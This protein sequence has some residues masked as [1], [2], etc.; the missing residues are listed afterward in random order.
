MKRPLLKPPAGDGEIIFLPDLASFLAAI[1]PSTRIGV[2]HQPYF[3]N[4]GVSLKF[5]FLES[6]PDACKEIIFLDTDRLNIKTKVPGP[7]GR[8][9]VL[10]FINSDQILS[11]FIVENSDIFNDF[12]NRYSKIL[13]KPSTYLTNAT[14]AAFSAFTDILLKNAHQSSLREVLAK[15]LLE[16]YSI[17]RDYRYLSDLCT[18]EGFRMFFRTIYEQQRSFREIFNVSLDEYRETFRFRYKH[19]PF[20]HLEEDELPFWIIREG[21]RCRLFTHDAEQ[22]DLRKAPIVPRAATLT[23]FLRLYR[24]DMFIHGVGGGNYEWVQDRIIER[25]FGRQPPPYAITSG[26]FLLGHVQERDLPYFLFQ[27]DRIRE[28]VRTFIAGMVKSS[29]FK[30]HPEQ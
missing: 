26:T 28:R 2:C 29:F 24:L 14:Y 16:F 27:P 6:F 7:G 11:D 5:L 10:T 30:G 23:I 17:Q 19:F 3:F 22:T 20:P 21:R 4:P 1:T 13:S 25:F 8:T 12:I 15:T 18:D 9:E